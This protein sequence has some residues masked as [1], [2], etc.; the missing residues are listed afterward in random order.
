MKRKRKLRKLEQEK[1][2]IRKLKTEGW[3]QKLK[4]VGKGMWMSAN[5]IKLQ[6]NFM[7]L[8]FLHIRLPASKSDPE[9]LSKD[10]QLAAQEHDVLKLKLSKLKTRPTTANFVPSKGLF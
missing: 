9:D 1:R 3:I 8:T 10:T 6:R 2:R 7:R 4:M 5:L